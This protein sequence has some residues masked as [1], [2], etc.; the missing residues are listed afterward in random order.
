[1]CCDCEAMDFD[2]EAMSFMT[3]TIVFNIKVYEHKFMNTI[4]VSKSDPYQ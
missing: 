3:G 4:E 2:G 1:M